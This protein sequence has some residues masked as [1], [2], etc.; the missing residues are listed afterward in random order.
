MISASEM[1]PLI[2]YCVIKD[3]SDGTFVKGDIIWRSENGDINSVAGNGFFPFSEQDEA[4]NDFEC[5]NAPD[6]RVRK[7]DNGYSTHEICEK[8]KDSCL[9]SRVLVR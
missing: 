2:P 1:K 4:S 8:S 3:S 7:V 9:K 6:W 5:V